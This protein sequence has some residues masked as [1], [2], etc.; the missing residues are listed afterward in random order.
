MLIQADASGL[1][2]RAILELSRDPVGIQEILD[3]QDVHGLNQVLFGLP[4][5]KEGR[6]TAKIYLFRTIYNR[7]KGYAFTLDPDFMHVSTSVAYWDEFGRKFYKK[8]QGI[9]QC[10]LRWGDLVSHGRPIVG[11]MGREWPISMGRDIRGDLFIPWTV[12]TNYPV[13]GTGA[14]IMMVARVS[15][16]NRLKK[17]Q[18][19][20]EV[21]LV[22]TVHDSIVVDTP[23]EYVRDIADL[24]YEV[25]PDIPSNIKK[26]FD[27]DW[28]VPL[29]CECK[30]GSNLKE[31]N[32]ILRLPIDN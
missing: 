30:Y 7:G 25:F 16:W 2:W 18:Y 31:M 29:D 9:D 23:E 10:H 21:K 15:F 11:P 6:T 3:G 22:S 8:Y 28:V 19:F 26:I 20:R 4:P 32:K 24:F 13:Q 14:D 1:E 17:K 27:Y 12:L 5:G